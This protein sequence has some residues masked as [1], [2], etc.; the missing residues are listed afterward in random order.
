METISFKAPVGTK[1]QLSLLAQ[2][3]GETPSRIAW[4]AVEKELQAGRRGAI[5]GAGKLLVSSP[6]TYD[7]EA[8]VLPAEEWEFVR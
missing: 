6:S 7:P 5:L 8:A 1:E 4:L 3:R 2:Q